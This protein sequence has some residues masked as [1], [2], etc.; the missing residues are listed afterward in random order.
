MLAARD[1]Q[2]IAATQEMITE[3]SVEIEGIVKYFNKRDDTNGTYRWDDVNLIEV[4]DGD[5]DPFVLISGAISYDVGDVV[6]FPDGTTF[7]VTEETAE[8]FKKMIRV[9]I[10]LHMIGSS[11]VDEIFNFMEESG[12]DDIDLADFI[13]SIRESEERN[14]ELSDF[15]LDSLTE[16]QRLTLLMMT[17]IPG[18]PN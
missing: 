4:S 6:Q 11:S 1:E 7:D 8:Y 2:Y 14:E 17:D 16:E 10:P 13:E 9:G 3:M 5:E 15:D 18:K 12:E